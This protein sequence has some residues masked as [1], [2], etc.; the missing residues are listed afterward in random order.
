VHTGGSIRIKAFIHPLGRS[1][2]N[3]GSSAF[4]RLFRRV[5]LN[6]KA[7]HETNLRSW[8]PIAPRRNSCFTWTFKHALRSIEAQCR[9]GMVTRRRSRARA[10]S[11]QC[12]Q[13]VGPAIT[14]RPGQG[15]AKNQGSVAFKYGYDLR[16][17]PPAKKG[18][19]GV[20][21]VS[22]D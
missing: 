11:R 16:P 7:C 19:L 10:P 21:K 20:K 9:R 14:R 18:E 3:P 6:T 17:C 13:C 4:N 15:K 8:L 5:R 1:R 2:H 22:S 12:P